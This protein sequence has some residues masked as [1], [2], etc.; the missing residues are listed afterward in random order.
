MKR[1]FVART[2]VDSSRTGA[3]CDGDGDDDGRRSERVRRRCSVALHATR[4][5]RPVLRVGEV[6][7]AQGVRSEQERKLTFALVRRGRRK[8][9]TGG[10]VSRP[11]P[12][13]SNGGAAGAE[14]VWAVR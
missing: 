8:R 14:D 10:W 2:N 5:E 12:Y 11:A 7:A 1:R 3:A 6:K 9:Q 4:L 13:G